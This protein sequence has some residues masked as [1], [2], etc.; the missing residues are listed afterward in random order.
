[1]GLIIC[2]IHGDQ[3]FYECCEHIYKDF[4]SGKIL[5]NESINILNDL[6]VCET[7]YAKYSF[8]EI[9]EY[10]LHEVLELDDK[11]G[12]QLEKKVFKKYELINRRSICVKCYEET[13]T[14]PNQA[15]NK[16]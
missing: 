2:K 3:F 8:P 1:M 12:Y 5:P 6:K 10:K 15:D 16:C 11:S 4:K 9:S 7:C 14:T 13:A